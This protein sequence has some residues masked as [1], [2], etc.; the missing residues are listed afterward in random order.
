MN[1]HIEVQII[2]HDGVPAFVVLPVA[3]YEALLARRGEKRTTLPHEV[4]KMNVQGG[5]SLLK[6]WRVWLGM[7]QSELAEKARMTQA[8]V[9]RFESGKAIPRADTLLKLSDALG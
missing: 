8:Q 2:C 6:A 3:D 5:F 1:A 7:S 9:A 4:V